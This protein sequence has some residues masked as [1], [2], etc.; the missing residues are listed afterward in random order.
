MITI[1]VYKRNEGI[2]D[3]ILGSL[4]LL[5]YLNNSYVV[6]HNRTLVSNVTEDALYYSFNYISSYIFLYNGDIHIVE[7][8]SSY[9]GA[10]DQQ[11]HEY[12]EQDM[13]YYVIFKALSL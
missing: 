2:Y 13:S 12:R 6:A 5:E 1:E 8:D 10:L 9:L 11:V 3:R 4:H 7:S